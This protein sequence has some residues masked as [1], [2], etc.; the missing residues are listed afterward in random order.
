MTPV[1]IC[2]YAL[3]QIGARASVTSISPS[4]GTQ[5]GD[6]CARHYQPRMDSLFRSALWNCARFQTPNGLTLL[7][8]RKGTPENPDGSVTSDPPFPWMYEYQ[9]PSSPYALRARYIVPM[10]QSGSTTS[11]PLMTGPNVILP[12]A[13]SSKSPI[14]FL[15]SSDIDANGNQIRVILTN[16]PQAQLVYTARVTDPTLWD[17]ELVDA[18]SM[19]LATWLV[20]PIQG[21]LQQAARCQQLVKELVVAARVGDGNEGPN[22]VDMTPDWIAARARGSGFAMPA[23]AAMWDSLPFANG[24][25]F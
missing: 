5:A 7:K 10:V 4:D 13:G 6:T 16:Q 24:E 9:W 22:I 23:V 19:Y 2:N 3:D 15:V 21:N 25:V 8:A 17:A 18:A 1:D 12:A 20:T 14:P 11:V